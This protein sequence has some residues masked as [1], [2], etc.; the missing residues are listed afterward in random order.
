MSGKIKCP[1]INCAQ[2]PELYITGNS[3]QQ[4]PTHY[5]RVCSYAYW[6]HVEAP[7]IEEVKAVEKAYPKYTRDRITEALTRNV[8]KPMPPGEWG[9]G[10]E[11]RM[12]EQLGGPDQPYWLHNK[13]KIYWR[14]EYEKLYPP[15]E[16]K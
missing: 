10:A 2:H 14:K 16:K 3:P 11:K 6:T 12:V 8:I 15:E 5:C 7:D 4:G 1:N 9:K 13:K